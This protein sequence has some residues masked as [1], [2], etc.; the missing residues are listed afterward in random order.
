MH[1]VREEKKRKTVRCESKI[2]R[3]GDLCVFARKRAQIRFDYFTVS[4]VC[5]CFFFFFEKKITFSSDAIFP[6]YVSA[7]CV[8]VLET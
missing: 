5:K 6:S 4:V 7:L 3:L 2:P 8:C 1:L